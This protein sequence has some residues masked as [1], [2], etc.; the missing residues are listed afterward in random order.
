[1][2]GGLVMHTP[3]HPTSFA[4]G[5]IL[6]AISIGHV[7]SCSGVVALQRVWKVA[8]LVAKC[9]NQES[10]APNLSQLKPLPQPPANQAIPKQFAGANH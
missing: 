4:S 10:T 1:M 7:L 5:T 2:V 9:T 3:T 6:V 8:K